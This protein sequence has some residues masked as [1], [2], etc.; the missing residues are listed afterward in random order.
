MKKSLIMIIIVSIFVSC[1]VLL[2]A[3]TRSDAG[4]MESLIQAKD[5]LAIGIQ[6]V[7]RQQEYKIVTEED[8]WKAYIE[9]YEDSAKIPLDKNSK[10][11]LVCSY[12]PSISIW[13]KKNEDESLDITPYDLNFVSH[14]QN[15]EHLLADVFIRKWNTGM[16]SHRDPSNLVKYAYFRYELRKYN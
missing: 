16:V 9:L 3:A 12:D 7:V 10:T 13:V 15:R 4:V 6:R 5:K 2:F 1:G 11:R 8:R 14:Y